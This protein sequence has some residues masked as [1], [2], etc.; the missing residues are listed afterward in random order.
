MVTAPSQCDSRLTVHPI[1]LC[2]EVTEPRAYL[3][4]DEASCDKRFAITEVS[5]SGVVQ[6]LRVSNGTDGPVLLVD[7]EQLLGAKQNRVVNLTILVPAHATL[8]VPVS[9]VE[10]GRWSWARPE[11]VP[12]PDMLYASGRARKIRDVTDSMRQRGDYRGN[13]AALWGDVAK[14]SSSYAVQST[15]GEMDAGD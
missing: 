3:T 11:F 6:E 15:T 12:A 7:G 1:C 9:C 13:Q 4:L 5:S 2:D 8:T 10:Q 14:L